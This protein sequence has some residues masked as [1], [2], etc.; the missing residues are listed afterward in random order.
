MGLMKMP[1]EEHNQWKFA[2][3]SLNSMNLD[4][5]ITFQGEI[6]LIVSEITMGKMVCQGEIPTVT[7]TFKVKK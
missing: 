6:M 5:K 4:S 2:V 1:R 3:F 7:E